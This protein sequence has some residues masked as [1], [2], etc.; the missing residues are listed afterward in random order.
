MESK[1]FSAAKKK[2]DLWSFN[3]GEYR[4]YGFVVFLMI[5]HGE[6]NI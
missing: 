6:M 3:N 1:F 2:N 5:F 4:V